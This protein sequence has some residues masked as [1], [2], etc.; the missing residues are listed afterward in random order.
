MAFCCTEKTSHRKS[1]TTFWRNGFVP[2]RRR[3]CTYYV[4]FRVCFTNAVYFSNLEKF[5]DLVCSGLLASF[6]EQKKNVLWFLRFRNTIPDESASY[7]G[8]CVPVTGNNLPKGCVLKS[9]LRL[10]EL[11]QFGCEDYSKYINP[12]QL[13]DNYE[14][15]D[16][17]LDKI[18]ENESMYSRRT[19]NNWN[20]FKFS[21][22][23]SHDLVRGL[24][25]VPY[26]VA[27][28]ARDCSI[29]LTFREVEDGTSR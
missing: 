12:L 9:I 5:C 11:D 13:E 27:S 14:Y 4:F 21:S 20:I 6:E 16:M 23:K 8:G 10:Q 28:V 26:L 18:M 25:F 2:K 17:L 7:P 3:K 15:V 24:F 22:Q 19:S 1:F 29:M